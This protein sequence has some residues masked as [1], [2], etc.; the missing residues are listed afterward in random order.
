MGPL[1]PR[2]ERTKKTKVESPARSD[3]VGVKLAANK[4]TLP[5]GTCEVHADLPANI[6]GAG[7]YRTALLNSATS[8][9]LA[10]GSTTW[11]GVYGSY[12]QCSPN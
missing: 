4:F 3:E 12:V 11:N 10:M 2:E 8:T 5:A 9:V 1:G 7:R 6:S